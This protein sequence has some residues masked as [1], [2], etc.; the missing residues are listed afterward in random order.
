MRCFII[1]NGP[2][3]NEHDLTKLKNEV[4][5]G[6]NRIY[7]K[8]DE[9]GFGVTYYFCV[10]SLQGGQLKD[11]I[12][13]YLRNEETKCIYTTDKWI[14]LFPKEQAKDIDSIGMISYLNSA[15]AMIGVAISIGF[16]QIY[17]IGIDMEYP[18]IENNTIQI[19]ELVYKLKDDCTDTYH[20][21]SNY[22]KGKTK[23]FIFYPNEIDSMFKAFNK[24]AEYANTKDIKI[25]N[26]GISGKL[27]IFKR[28]DYNSL[29]VDKSENLK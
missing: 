1:G 11:E 27:D 21:D 29:F 9:M 24:I 7:L 19:S 10:D 3:L 8:H 28:V 6:C 12:N 13:E 17:L 22:W 5:F 25:Y 23:N 15:V 2:S 4:T 26:A 14:N 18:N 16:N 20:F